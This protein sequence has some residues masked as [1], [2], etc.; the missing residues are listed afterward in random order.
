MVEYHF[1]LVMKLVNNEE[2]L[3]EIVTKDANIDANIEKR[4]KK[5]IGLISPV[6]AIMKDVSLG[7][8]YFNIG[9]LFRNSN[10]INGILTNSEVWYGLKK[11]HVEQLEKIDEMFIRKL[12]SAHSKTPTEALY[13]ETGL[14]QIRFIIQM[15]RLMYWWHIVIKTKENSL[16]KKVYEA[17]KNNPARDDWIHAHHFSGQNRTK[18]RLR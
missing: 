6:I 12:F 5:G 8:H 4:V 3:G 2:Y 17:Q 14:I 13:I 10:I 16:V 18:Y 11:K 7:R 1:I 9:L 15:R